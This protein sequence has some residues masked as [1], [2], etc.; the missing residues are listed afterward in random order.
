MKMYRHTSLNPVWYFYGRHC[1]PMFGGAVAAG[2]G[3]AVSAGASMLASGM[4]E[5][6]AAAADAQNAKLT[7]EQIM[8]ADQARRNANSYQTPYYNTG[9]AAQNKLAY[10]LGVSN[11]A[12]VPADTSY[13]AFL[14][15]KN[16]QKSDLQMQLK[17]LKKLPKDPK[18]KAKAIAQRNKLQNQLNQVKTALKGDSSSELFQ[19]W[20]SRQAGTKKT[21]LPITDEYGSLLR[22]N[23]EQFKFEED[24]GYQ[25]RKA[26][27]ERD[28]NTQMASMGLTNSGA[29]LRSGMEFSQGLA[30]QEY[31]NAWQRYLDRN[32]IYNQN[33][34]FKVGTL[35]DFAATGQQAANQLS[36]NE[37]VYGQNVTGAKAAQ[38]SRSQENITG[39]ANARS[40]GVAGIGNAV[41]QGI[42]NYQVMDALRQKEAAAPT[43]K[44]MKAQSAMM[45]TTGSNYV[46]PVAQKMKR[47][48]NVFAGLRGV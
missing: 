29:A 26:Q 14:G 46:Q 7:K 18:A 40:A 5:D 3:A 43:P 33:R 32:N 21:T 22:D 10:M 8:L 47:R 25:F 1:L 34:G 24:P 12:E 48:P 4:Q 20:Q 39:A 35:S 41:S 27:G 16:R 30:A 44:V 13:N 37:N 42:N 9:T 36:N 38:N 23:P 45:G 15:I 17:A 2:V 6:G 11:E 19:S 31:G 28:L